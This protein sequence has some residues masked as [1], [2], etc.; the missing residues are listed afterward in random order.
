MS[1]LWI[2]FHAPTHEL[3]LIQPLGHQQEGLSILP[4]SYSHFG[5][6]DV[7]VVVPFHVSTFPSCQQVPGW[8]KNRISFLALN[9]STWL[10]SNVYLQHSNELQVKTLPRKRMLHLAI[11]FGG[12]GELMEESH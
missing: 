4:I 1:V 7:T 8:S 2:L 3:Y 5:H 6:V 12:N 9:E 10:D 11:G